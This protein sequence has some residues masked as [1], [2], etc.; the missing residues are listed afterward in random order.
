MS[1]GGLNEGTQNFVGVAEKL[2]IGSGE[3]YR[4]E[5]YI[6]DNADSSTLAQWDKQD[7]SN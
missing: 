5:K 3:T 4:K 6:V 2:G 7:I 1:Q